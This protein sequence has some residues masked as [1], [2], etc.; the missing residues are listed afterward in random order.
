[1]T[2]AHPE[3]LNNYTFNNVDKNTGQLGK[4]K[5]ATTDSGNAI[6]GLSAANTSQGR[7]V[8]A[9]FY[10]NY[11]TKGTTPDQ[12][13]NQLGHIMNNFDRPDG[14]TIDA[15][16]SKGDGGASTSKSSSEVS[17]FTVMKDLSR[18]K[19]YIR[20]IN[21]SLNWAVVDFAS[22]KDVKEVKALQAYGINN[23]GAQDLS[24]SFLK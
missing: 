10:A 16:G 18:G 23:A 19:Y 5:L 20:S 24:S 8:K 2:S 17:D 9:A 7:F 4:L 14:L 3:N 15:A 12:A 21:N 11:V 22:L 13:I 1:M 6:A